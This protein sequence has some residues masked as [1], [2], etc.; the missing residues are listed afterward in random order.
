MQRFTILAVLFVCSAAVPAHGASQ[1]DQ[2]LG[3]LRVPNPLPPC[4]IETAVTQL[5]Q[6]VGLPLGFERASDCMNNI[7]PSLKVT[8]ASDRLRS[9]TVRDA[10]NHLVALAPGYAWKDMNGV[11]VVRSIRA[12]DDPSDPLNLH[13]PSF[14]LPG[15][16]FQSALSVVLVMREVPG[17][18]WV[19]RS[20]TQDSDRAN[21]P[22]AMTFPG[23]TMLD[24][25][26][27]IVRA[28]GR[29]A[30]NLGLLD[31]QDAD[32][33]ISIRMGPLPNGPWVAVDTEIRGLIDRLAYR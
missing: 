2:K 16:T 33:T 23:G 25:L 14:G 5:A 19:T 21:F 3:V 4:G 31:D 11:A 10:L 12:W 17:R 7:R 22:F 28:H 6:R 18:P 9:V 27:A 24:A 29:A 13:V 30:W 26:N 32:P 20:R 8:E 1:L 15:A